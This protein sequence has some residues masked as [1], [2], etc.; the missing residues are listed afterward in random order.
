MLYPSPLLPA[1]VSQ[2]KSIRGDHDVGFKVDV[3]VRDGTNSTPAPVTLSMTVPS[4]RRSL[5]SV[6]STSSWTLPTC[7][8]NNKG[9]SPTIGQAICLHRSY[10]DGSKVGMMPHSGSSTGRIVPTAIAVGTGSVLK[11]MLVAVTKQGLALTS[12]MQLAGVVRGGCTRREQQG[13]PRLAGHA[14]TISPVDGSVKAADPSS[15]VKANFS[16]W[17]ADGGTGSV[18]STTQPAT[19]PSAPCGGLMGRTTDV[20]RAGEEPLITRLVE[21]VAGSQQAVPIGNRSPDCFGL[22][23]ASRSK[24]ESTLKVQGEYYVLPAW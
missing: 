6:S 14:P 10:S 11:P 21:Q 23:G 5:S 20:G 19:T 18:A 22:A 3:S 17:R 12:G 4:V 13:A 16:W 24:Y 15:K 9:R 7:P 8:S 2:S 1:R